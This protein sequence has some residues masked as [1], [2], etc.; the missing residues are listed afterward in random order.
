M[1]TEHDCSELPL[2]LRRLGL[3]A[4]ALAVMLGTARAQSV[5]TYDAG[6]GTFPEVP[7]WKSLD[8]ANPEQ[9][10]LQSGALVLGTSDPAENMTYLW[11][12]PLSFPSTFIF[13][14]RMRFVSGAS[15]TSVRAPAVLGITTSPLVGNALFIAQDEIFALASNTVKG[16]SAAVD[17]DGAFHTYR[18][19]VTGT[20]AGSS[21]A[22]FYDA[23]TTPRIQSAL[24]A[25]PDFNGQ[26]PRLYFGEGSVLAFGTAEW[27]EVSHNASAGACCGQVNS[28]GKLEN[29]GSIGIV[30]GGTYD[31][32]T[33]N[34]WD[35]VLPGVPAAPSPGLLIYGF[36]SSSPSAPIATT[37]GS[38][39][40]SPL[41]R[42]TVALPDST[43]G[44]CV[45]PT[46]YTWTTWAAFVDVNKAAGTQG[47]SAAGTDEVWIQAWHRDPLNPGAANFSKLAGPFFVAP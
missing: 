2:R 44:G 30:A 17:T 19:E 37:F 31:A 16:A 3:A 47:F 14:A 7:C 1:A 38:L 33:G 18:I 26:V 46:Q 24:F 9:P 45:S 41:F 23:E 22:V 25:D 27:Q 34:T 10:M 4:S 42:A 35:I 8:S 12:A 29:L 15:S 21:F 20:V 43:S 32:N 6:T 28:C 36:G 40:L 39:C 11:Q 13:E 5:V